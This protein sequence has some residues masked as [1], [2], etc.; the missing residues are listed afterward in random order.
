MPIIISQSGKNAIRLEPT[1]FAQE[2]DLQRYIEDN[3]E[4]IPLEDIKEDVQFLLL[5]REFP[6]GVGSIDALGVDSD[7]EI[8]IIETKLYKNPDKRR[9]IAQVL[10]YGAALWS[11]NEN[12][13]IW[14][15][16]LERRLDSKGIDLNDLLE[17][18]FGGSENV[19]NGMID[20]LSTGAF[21]FIV[22]MD[23]VPSALKDL[24]LYINQNSTFSVYGVELEYY[25]HGDLKI[26]KPQV[27]G[28]EIKR[29]SVTSTASKRGTWDETSFFEKAEDSVEKDE[30]TAIKKLY[31]F[32]VEISDDIVWGSG[33]VRGTFNPRINSIGTKSLFAVFSDGKL[34]FHHK[35]Y[36]DHA[37]AKPWMESMVGK[38]KTLSPINNLFAERGTERAEI[39][40]DVWTPLVDEMIAILQESLQEINN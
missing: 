26:L 12:P 33:S 21:R 15:R 11:Q 16:N 29:K 20:T 1:R 14:I 27:F 38:I 18:E 6:V 5:D 31:D 36:E 34:Q 40:P 25:V 2:A 22:L 35:W 10:D 30:L 32:C 39:P 28:S 7:G 17:A 4:A 37:D 19:L 3:P 8:Y 13:E 23:Q 24:I 9:V